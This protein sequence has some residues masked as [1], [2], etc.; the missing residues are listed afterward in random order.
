MNNLL[1]VWR[2]RFGHY[3]GEIQKYMRY[4]FTGH[5]A[6]VI[7]FVLG[8]G[9]YKYSEWL[10]TASS[11]FPAIWLTGA[12]IGLVVG[13]SRPV[14]LIRKPDEVYL[15]PLETKLPLYFK[16]A[17]KYTFSSQMILVLA[18]YLVTWPMLRQV[19]GLKPS[20]I[21]VGLVAALLIKYW[22]VHSEFMYRW[23]YKGHYAW[24]DRLVRMIISGVLISSIL[25]VQI[26]PIV[27]LVVILVVYPINWRNKMK[28]LPFP[29]EHFVKLE[30]NRMMGIYRFANY[31][32]DVPHIHGSIKRRAWLDFLYGVIPYAK[33]NTQEYLVF[34]TFIR[35][36]DHFY[37]WVRLTAIAALVA[38]FVHMPIVIGVIVGAMAFATAIQLKQA[39]KSSNDFRMDMLF[40]LPNNSRQLASVKIVRYTIIVQGL[41]VGLAGIMTPYFYIQALIVWVIGEMTLRLSK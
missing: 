24:V 10:K 31:F 3:M 2:V 20:L 13:L 16:K 21:F 22:N 32:T 8:A 11:D 37:L 1:D 4:V 27:V 35:T 41:I 33:K 23:A 15:L 38:A 39:L 26:I 40:P 30:E 5:L 36:D 29:Y 12:I 9:G 28:E 18:L 25:S 14:T 6:I 34:R 17:L 19:A 7:M